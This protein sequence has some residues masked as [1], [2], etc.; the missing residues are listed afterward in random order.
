MQ[1]KFGFRNVLFIVIATAFS[2]CLSLSPA[3]MGDG[4]GH[5]VEGVTDDGRQTIMISA[6]DESVEYRFFDATYESVAIRPAQLTVSNQLVGVPVEVLVK[7]SFPD[8]CSEL[9]DVVQQRAGN[10]ILVTLTM[11]RPMGA[12]CASVM[13]PYRYYLD[14]EGNYTA[15]SYSLKLNE[16]SHPFVIR[17]PVQ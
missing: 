9:H 17:P 13:R 10:L 4:Y 3:E 12:V 15:G 2:G 8:S 16:S 7:G 14:L 6:P 5:R 1:I 11:R